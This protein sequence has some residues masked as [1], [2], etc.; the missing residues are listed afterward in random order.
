M[1][2]K[3]EELSLENL[4]M[5]VKMIDALSS[6]PRVG[7]VQRSINKSEAEDV[8]KHILLTAYIGIVL[9]H[10]Y[11]ELC[12]N[13]INCDKVSTLCLVHD[14]HES[15]IGNIAGDVRRMI[16]NFKNIELKKLEEL[17][18]GYPEYV[19]KTIGTYF[20]EY[21]ESMSIEA[22]LVRISDKLATLL[23]AFRYLQQGN[24]DVI[25]LVN[26]Y[27]NEVRS[28]SSYVRCEEFKK[29]IENVITAVCKEV[30]KLCSS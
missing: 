2:L 1:E 22:V 9:C 24:R 5:L 18:K 14:I 11:R 30:S 21:R 26:F 3:R 29:M 12:N 7:W 15:A 19:S 25:D 8:A 17:F 20:L 4:T 10:T 13:K 23:R 6:I 27:L 28:L 16:P